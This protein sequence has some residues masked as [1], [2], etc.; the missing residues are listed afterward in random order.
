MVM[1]S[2]A[3]VSTRCMLTEQCIAIDITGKYVLFQQAFVSRHQGSVK[4]T[5][6]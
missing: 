5:A 6:N 3:N 4:E 1:L 2:H